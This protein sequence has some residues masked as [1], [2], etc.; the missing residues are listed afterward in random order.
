VSLLRQ[1]ELASA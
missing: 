1:P